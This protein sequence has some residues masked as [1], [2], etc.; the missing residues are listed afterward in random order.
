MA[1]INNIQYTNEGFGALVLSVLKNNKRHPRDY[2]NEQEIKECFE[3]Y[4]NQCF[5]CNLPCENMEIDHIIPLAGGGSNELNNLQPLCKDCHKTKTTLEKESGAYKSNDLEGSIFNKV[6]LD[7]M[8]NSNEFKSW[9]FIERVPITG[10]IENVFRYD[11][12]KCRRNNAYFSDFEFP[13]YSV[14]DISRPFSGIIRCGMYLVETCNTYPFRGIGW[15]TQP[16]VQYAL[17][18]NIIDLANIKGECIPSNKLPKDYFQKP[19][20]VLL[21]AFESDPDLQKLAPNT[22]V[23]LFGR[24]KSTASRTKFTTC[25]MEASTWWGE[26]DPRCDVFIRSIQLDENDKLYEGIFNETVQVESTKYPLYKQ[27]LELEAIELHKL[28]TLLIKK[29]VV[30]LVTAVKRRLKFKNTG[31]IRPS[32]NIKKNP[33]QKY[34]RL[35]FYLECAEILRSI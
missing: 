26:S 31:M 5:V 24:T 21:K 22:L 33:T 23:G 34:W 15:Y 11:L 4:D 20:D 30:I 10:P 17:D 7:H 2:L 12:C 9:A 14:M 18:N 13:V 29:G 6:T 8:T 35:K 16:L 32:K 1:D 19:I 25:P 3:L 27:I 28:E